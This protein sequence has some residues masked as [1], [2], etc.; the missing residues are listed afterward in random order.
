MHAPA[1]ASS[2]DWG[3]SCANHTPASSECQCCVLLRVRPQP[4]GCEA[5]QGSDTEPWRLLGVPDAM[6]RPLPRTHFC[7][8]FAGGD[9]VRHFLSLR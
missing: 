1:H 5:R 6:S 3:E 2:G 4:A 7:R 9:R 8:N